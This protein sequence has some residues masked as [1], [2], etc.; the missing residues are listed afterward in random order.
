MDGRS[1]R[2]QEM[3]EQRRAQILDAALGVFARQGYHGTS[4]SD[5]V[6]AAGV[7]R[8]T[9]YQ[10]F[11]SKKTIFLELLDALLGELKGSVQGVDPAAEASVPEQLVLTIRRIFEVVLANRAL[12]SIIFREA[13]GLD[14]DVDARLTGFNDD[15]MT[16]IKA[17][18]MLGQ[19]G[20]LVRSL[21][22][23]IAAH[24]VMGTLRYIA[25]R[26]LVEDGLAEAD[27]ERLA[28]EVVAFNLQGVM[29]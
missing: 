15:F 14:D 19:Q 28:R 7:A 5:L 22:L 1:A 17:A 6:S 4:I 12:T 24:C 29:I 20:G 25:Q 10:Y 21:D 8:G 26:S 23:D 9:F 3:R 13:V 18:L 2:A 11:D 16:Y 27:V